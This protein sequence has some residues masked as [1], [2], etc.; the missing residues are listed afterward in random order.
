MCNSKL[1]D[2][3]SLRNTH[4]FFVSCGK[5]QSSFGCSSTGI[6]QNMDTQ[7]YSHWPYYLVSETSSELHCIYFQHCFK[8]IKVDTNVVLLSDRV[9]IK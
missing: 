1:C 2:S 6:Y 9:N 7:A 8:Q 5:N 3:Y 4:S